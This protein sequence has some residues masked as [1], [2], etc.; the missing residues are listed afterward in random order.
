MER[1]SIYGRVSRSSSE[2]S[3]SDSAVEAEQHRRLQL[4]KH[5]DTMSRPKTNSPTTMTTTSMM[6]M[7]PIMPLPQQAASQTADVPIT[8]MSTSSMAM[9]MKWVMRD[10]QATDIVNPSDTFCPS[11]LGVGGIDGNNIGKD[12]DDVTIVGY[13]VNCGAKERI[14]GIGIGRAREELHENGSVTG[15]EHSV[16]ASSAASGA[17]LSPRLEMRL[18]LNQDILGD[19]DLMNYDPGPNLTSILGYLFQ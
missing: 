2:S 16:A 7:A 19:E 10:G 13:N 1:V 12:E 5:Q 4:Q 18:A 17:G 9:T 3:S 15:T 8:V 6:M 14:N 11:V